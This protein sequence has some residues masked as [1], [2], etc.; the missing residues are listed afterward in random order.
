MQ[1]SLGGCDPTKDGMKQKGADGTSPY[2][3]FITGGEGV[4]IYSLK[5]YPPQACEDLSP[6]PPFYENSFLMGDRDNCGL[7]F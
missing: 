3:L 2:R 6:P 5:I 1:V 7:V 4:D